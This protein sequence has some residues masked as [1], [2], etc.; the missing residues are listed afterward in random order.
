MAQRLDRIEDAIEGYM[1]QRGHQA[2]DRSVLPGSLPRSSSDE[3]QADK[4]A[5]ED[6][7]GR[8]E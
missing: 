7:G 4:T 3:E 2:L 5:D 1:R 6:K 8:E